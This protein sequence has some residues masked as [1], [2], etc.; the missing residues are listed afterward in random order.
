MI[1]GIDDIIGKMFYNELSTAGKKK[2]N[3][4]AVNKYNSLNVSEREA[5]NSL[6]E[7]KSHVYIWYHQFGD[8]DICAAYE[9]F[10]DYISKSIKELDVNKEDLFNSCKVIF[11]QRKVFETYFENGYIRRNEFLIYN[12][13]KYERECFIN[14][15]FLMIKYISNLRPT[16]FIFNK[17]HM[18]GSTTIEMINS[19][20]VDGCMGTSFFMSF[21][22]TYKIN[23]YMIETWNAFQSTLKAYDLVIEWDG[24]IVNQSDAK[25]VNRMN[26]SADRLKDYYLKLSNLKETLAFKQAHFYTDKIHR[27]F[28]REKDRIDIELRYQ[29]YGL[30]TIICI[31]NDK[32]ASAILY[33]NEIK[34]LK[35]EKSCTEEMELKIDFYHNYMLAYIQ[36]YNDQEADARKSA[37]KAIEVAYKSKDEKR[38]FC[39][40]LIEHM[41]RFSGWKDDIWMGECNED[42]DEKLLERA[43]KYGFLNHLAHIY[44]YAFDNDTE[45]YQNVEGLEERIVHWKKGF[46]IAKSMQNNKLM[47][48]AC[49]KSI[50]IASTSGYYNVSDYFYINY[51]TPIV[52]ETKDI[53]EEANIYNGLGY[54][55]CM[56]NDYN[57]ANDYF[58]KAFDIFW[59]SKKYEYAAETLY[60][61]SVNCIKARDF[62][63]GD[64]YIST[65]MKILEVLKT[66]MMRVCHLSKLYGIKAL[67]TFMIGNLYTAANYIKKSEQ[68]LPANLYN[69]LDEQF[70]IYWRDDIFL[71]NYVKMCNYLHNG[72]KNNALKH[73]NNVV[74]VAE[75]GGIFGYLINDCNDFNE[76]VGRFEEKKENVYLKSNLELSQYS[77][78]EIIEETKNVSLS[79]ECERMRDDID[80][81]TAWKQLLNHFGKNPYL[82]VE[83]AANSFK[84]NYN[85]DSFIVI[86]YSRYEPA[87]L[88]NGSDAYL[89]REKLNEITNYFKN[90][91]MEIFASKF[92]TGFDAYKQILSL[93]DTSSIA[94]FFAVPFFK[95]E[96]LDIIIITYSKIRNTWNKQ[97]NR[98]KMDESDIKFHCIV[99]QELIE[100]IEKINDKIELEN[101]TE[102]E[103]IN[104]KLKNLASLDRLTQLYNRQG[105]YDTIDYYSEKKIQNFC[106]AFID[107]DNFKYYNDHF[108]HD[109]GDVILKEV[110]EIFKGVCNEN[111]IAVRYGGDEFLL[112]LNTPDSNVAADRVKIVYEVFEKNN[113]FIDTISK[114]MAKKIE[115]PEEYRISCSIGIARV[116]GNNLKENISTAI[117]NAD[118]TLYY[119]KRTLKK[120]CKTWDEVK[121]II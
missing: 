2:R 14:S 62:N 112:M 118:K 102:L 74:E 31:F 88:F 5:Y 58:N 65:C 111:D 109:I 83:N 53:Y 1:K 57:M 10:L 86:Q 52:L 36:M 13:A 103:S 56:E 9:P 75:G 81:L 93:F 51:S 38:I 45:I 49:R 20:I 110:A 44:V 70:I 7:I 89:D 18:A 12:E 11:M 91:P 77:I 8:D 42:F 73:W 3:V 64:K 68:Y 72:D 40:E 32:I 48:E 121:D 84:N 99:F 79:V 107:L 82:L 23:S 6:K 33:C 17:V 97:E 71:C 61:M 54:N 22:N 47:L 37:M 16:M 117:T 21:D 92:E 66:D 105:F 15:L 98:F 100:A 29:F 95:N 60:N 78:D 67:C 34:L 115:I 96:Q 27:F 113:Y 46:E 4:V 104:K 106:V 19:L 28:E 108:G 69:G 85:V 30:F 35:N 39:A 43:E 90:N 80:F 63:N 55:K 26:I 94:T 114:L 87:I 120:Q 41:S 25:A 116:E 50:M 119:I 101:K 24:E 76:F 59:K